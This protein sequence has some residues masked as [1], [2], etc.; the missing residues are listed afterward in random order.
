MQESCLCGIVWVYEMPDVGEL[1]IRHKGQMILDTSSVRFIC[2]LFS[3]LE[4]FRQA[5]GATICLIKV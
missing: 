4:D 2:L 1:L 5:E 3:L